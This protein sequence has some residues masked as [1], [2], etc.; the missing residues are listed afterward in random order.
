MLHLE[1][2]SKIYV[3]KGVTLLKNWKSEPLK[4]LPIFPEFPGSCF[5]LSPEGTSQGIFAV[6]T[7]EGTSDTSRNLLPCSSGGNSRSRCLHFA[8]S[9]GCALGLQMIDFL[10]CP[11]MAVFGPCVSL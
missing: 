2:R 8:S 11:H 6:Q 7:P 3:I 4:Q 5:F 1:V 9:E 10:L